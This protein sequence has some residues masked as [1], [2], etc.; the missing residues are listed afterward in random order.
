V[1]LSTYAEIQVYTD[2]LLVAFYGSV[3]VEIMSRLHHLRFLRLVNEVG[4]KPVVCFA[5][6]NAAE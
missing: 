6:A 5:S 4:V 2:A 3:L 1:G